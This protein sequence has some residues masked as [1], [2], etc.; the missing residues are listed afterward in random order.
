MSTVTICKVG[1]RVG[2][3]V[4]GD[5]RAIGESNSSSRRAVTRNGAGAWRSELRTHNFFYLAELLSNF[6]AQKRSVK[7]QNKCFWA[8]KN[9]CRDIF[10][11]IV[12][13]NFNTESNTN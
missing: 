7:S 8:E 1:F 10:M 9:K 6:N 4:A 12:R 5:W 11:T 3:S 2:E 13:P